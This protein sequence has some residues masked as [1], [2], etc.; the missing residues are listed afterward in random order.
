MG[1][2]IMSDS[3]YF[4]NFLCNYFF[5]T[6]SQPRNTREHSAKSKLKPMSNIQNKVLFNTKFVVYSTEIIKRVMP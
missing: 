2:L 6:I 4:K 5:K 1:T 3:Q